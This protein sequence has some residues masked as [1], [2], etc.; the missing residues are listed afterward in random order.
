MSHT[1]TPC[2]SNAWWLVQIGVVFSVQVEP[3][4]AVR[5]ELPGPDLAL[6]SQHFA[7]GKKCTKWCELNPVY[8]TLTILHVNN[9]EVF[10]QSIANALFF[11]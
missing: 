5:L 6:Q 9:V 11:W 2:L 10:I 8:C 1:C 4:A 3:S 7:G